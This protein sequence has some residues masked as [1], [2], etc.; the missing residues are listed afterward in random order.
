M[1]NSY[2]SLKKQ[3]ILLQYSNIYNDILLK[4]DEGSLPL[5]ILKTG[6]D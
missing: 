6:Q 5:L 2:L 4:W 3:K 1:A